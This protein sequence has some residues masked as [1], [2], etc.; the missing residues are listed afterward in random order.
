VTI[1]CGS[2]GGSRRPL[3]AAC[4]AFVLILAACGGGSSV[5]TNVTPVTASPVATAT[6]ITGQSLERPRVEPT[7]PSPQTAAEILASLQ[8]AGLPIDATIVFDASTD[9]NQLLG[10]PGQYT[11]KASFHDSRLAAP[12]TSLT[13]DSGGSIETFASTA[14][15]QRRYDY[16]VGLGQASSLLVEYDYLKGTALLR[17]AH[18]LTPDQANAYST[19]FTQIVG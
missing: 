13:I 4:I 5:Q 10:R 18:A 14:D 8:A 2:R 15:A 11:G 3:I 12:S 6:A 1:D 9:A 7:T 17:I 19:A 16:I